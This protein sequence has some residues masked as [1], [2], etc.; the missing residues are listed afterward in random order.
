MALLFVFKGVCSL[1]IDLPFL[2]SPALAEPL[3]FNTFA[4]IAFS[5]WKA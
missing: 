4:R 5:P 1:W 2:T 3:F